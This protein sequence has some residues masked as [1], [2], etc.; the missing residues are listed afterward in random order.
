MNGTKDSR[1]IGSLIKS[2]DPP[3]TP[4]AYTNPDCAKRAG[5]IS[6]NLVIVFEDQFLP[7]A[8]PPTSLRNLRA[9]YIIAGKQTSLVWNALSEH[10]EHMRVYLGWDYVLVFNK[11]EYYDYFLP[12]GTSVAYAGVLQHVPVI[13]ESRVPWE[14]IDQF[15]SDIEAASKFRDLRLW[16][17]DGLHAETVQHAADV[18]GQKLDN[19]TWAIRK[20]GLQTYSG[21]ISFI[22]KKE[23]LI[24]K[25][26]VA[27]G[28][29]ILGGPLYGALSA[30]LVLVGEATAFAIER[31]VSMRDVKRGKD[32][33]IA[34]LYDL[35][36]FSD[37]HGGHGRR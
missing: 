1:T 10:V 4:F 30:G 2:I 11:Q 33:E 35:R 37:K 12:S 9:D 7:E 23:S 17:K 26:A 24:S 27:I 31:T 6:A 36:E 25:A 28:G 34:V 19:Y 21:V 32:S 14:Q 3:A 22:L 16:L 5:L 29:T 8:L 20:H 15:K 18:I 13:D